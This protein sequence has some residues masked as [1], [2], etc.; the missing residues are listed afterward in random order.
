MVTYFKLDNK[1]K[2]RKYTKF[3][4]DDCKKE[5]E[6][7]FDGYKKKKNN[8]CNK[9]SPLHNPQLLKKGHS[10]GYNTRFKS[11]QNGLSNH[12]IYRSWFSM[13]NRCYKEKAD[14]YKW[15]GGRGIKICDEWKENF[16]IFFEWSIKNNWKE[17][18]E[19]DRINNNG[20]Y[21]PSNCQWITHKENVRKQFL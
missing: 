3:I 15:Y 9:C 1:G 4:C 17:G 5:I 7:R 10:F 13:K 11:T 21:E 8:L 12:P 18:L 2:K 14:N 20:N 6:I 19:I 16:L